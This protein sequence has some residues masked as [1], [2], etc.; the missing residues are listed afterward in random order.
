MKIR[1]GLVLAMAVLFGVVGCASGGGGGGTTLADL[2][3]A[4]GGQ[5]ERPR[6][7]EN[8]RAAER[9]LEDAEAAEDEAVA[10]TQYQQALASAEAGI[11]EDPTNP[12]AYRLGALA[13]LGLEDYVKAGEYFDEAAELRP[14]YEFE[15]QPIRE[16]TWIDLYQ[17]AAPLV[18]SG[19]YE[20]AAVVFENANAIYRGRPEGMITLGQLYAQLRQHDLALENLDAAQDLMA[21]PE[22]MST[23]DSATAAGWREQA[24][25][26]PLL[27]AQVLADAGRFEEASSAYR[28]LADADPENVELTRGLATILMQMGSEAEALEVYADLLDRPGLSAEDYYA[29]GVGFYQA[30]DYTRAVQAFGRAADVSPRDRD[31]L[32]MWARSMQLDS[33]YA[34]VPRVAERWLELDPYSQNGYLILAQAANANGDQEATREA[35]QTVEGLEVSVDQLQLRRF[36]SG[37]GT[38]SGQVMNKTLDAGA[39]VTLRFTFYGESGDPIGTVSETVSVAGA[40]LAQVFTVQ[41]D[42]AQ[43]IAG[44]GYELTV[45]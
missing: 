43:T 16:R 34:D 23:V 32:E 35:V 7:T 19:D 14:L 12:L 6:E 13:A 29:I 26:I 27:R 28:E 20:G 37:G 33:A 30:S 24:G 4:A 39:T 18:S 8:T 40:D 10:R 45:G 9:A 36:A 3:A 44:Y 42:S 38:V 1:Y 25:D 41:F 11:A 15:D 31:A 17:E 21:D 5:G 2:T 22:L